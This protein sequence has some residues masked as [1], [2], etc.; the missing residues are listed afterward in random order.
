MGACVGMG[1]GTG[2]G[3][4]EGAGTGIRVGAGIGLSLGFGVGARVSHNDPS[5]ALPPVLPVVD[6]PD[7][8]MATISGAISPHM[9]LFRLKFGR[10]VVTI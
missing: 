8:P 3:S 9:A 5:P 1:E 10:K 4:L 2:L 6:K 7:I